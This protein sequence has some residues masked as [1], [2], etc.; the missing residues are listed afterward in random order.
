MGVDDFR[1][2]EGQKG[3]AD[4]RLGLGRVAYRMSSF[5]EAKLAYQTSL[6]IYRR[7]QE[8]KGKAV[9]SPGWGIWRGLWAI[10]N[11]PNIII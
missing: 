5:E 2:I 6:E 11:G 8:N 4:A 1:E 10:L 7:L 9:S 3:A